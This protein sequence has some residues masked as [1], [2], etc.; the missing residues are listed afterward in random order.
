MATGTRPPVAVEFTEWVGRSA[1]EAGLA[2]LAA[3]LDE[4]PC[5]HENRGTLRFD[6]TE[7]GANPWRARRCI[8]GRPL[9]G[10]KTHH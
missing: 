1:D 10:W 9:Q 7:H 6:E 5:R 3:E 2:G 8:R 4:R